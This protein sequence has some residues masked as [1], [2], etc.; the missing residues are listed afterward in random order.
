MIMFHILITHFLYFVCVWYINEI[1]NS[2]YTE[3]IQLNTCTIFQVTLSNLKMKTSLTCIL[4]ICALLASIWGSAMGR[5]LHLGSCALTVHT[6]EL[7]H[8]F[9][10]I[11][12]NMV[13]NVTVLRGFFFFYQEQH[14]LT[15]NPDCVI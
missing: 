15:C 13:S 12:H 1:N 10:Q 6:H 9:E 11:R 7:R 2:I 5:R 4:A 3:F 8:H 14:G